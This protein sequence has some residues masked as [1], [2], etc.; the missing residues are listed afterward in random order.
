VR[1]VWKLL[2]DPILLL[3]IPLSFQE[4]PESA[5]KLRLL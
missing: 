1:P 5:L 2:E 4:L 3:L